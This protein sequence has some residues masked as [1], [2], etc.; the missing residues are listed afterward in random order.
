MTFIGGMAET[1]RAIGINISSIEPTSVFLSPI[2]LISR[3]RRRVAACYGMT[4]LE[5]TGPSRQWDQARPR[6]IAMWLAR[7]MTSRSY[8]EIGRLFGGRDHSTVMHA[9]RRVDN[10]IAENNE[11]GQDALV[12]R[13][14]LGG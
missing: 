4:V 3:I 6:M 13:K 11:W 10:W 5:L 8:P 9:C 12:L 14:E 7:K 2:G 1:A